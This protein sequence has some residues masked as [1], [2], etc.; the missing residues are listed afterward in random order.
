MILDL[1][2]CDLPVMGEQRVGWSCLDCHVNWDIQ[3]VLPSID[4]GMLG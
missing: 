2:E 4:H 1:L 3:D